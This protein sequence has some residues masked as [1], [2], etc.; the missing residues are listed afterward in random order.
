MSR[1]SSVLRTDHPDGPRLL[2]D[3]GATN[4]RF[5]LEFAPGRIEQIEVLACDDFRSVEAVVRAYLSRVQVAGDTQGIRHAAIAI[6][7]PI[8]GDLVRMTNRDWS[9][10]IETT[11]IAL[12]LDTLLVVN[13][14]TALAMAIPRLDDAQRLKIGGGAARENA[15]IGLLGPGTGLGVSG[16]IP[17]EDR[18]ITLGSEGGHV[19]FAPCDERELFVLQH[20]WRRYPHVSAERLVSGPGIELTYQALAAR[21]GQPAATLTTPQIVD[22]A[23]AGSDVLCVETVECFCAMLGTVAANVA[24]TLGAFGGIYIG[25]GI[26]PRLGELFARSP[27]RARFEAKGRFSDYMA[28]I[29]SYLITAPYPAFLG[30]SAILAEALRGAG[31]RSESS[32][33][34]DSVRAALERL[35]RAEQQVAELVLARPRAV[36]GDPVGEIARQA[37]VSQPTVIRF[38][39][40]LGFQGLSDFKLKL[41]SGLTGTV[42]IR[43]SQVRHGDTAPDISAKVLDNTASAILRLRDSLNTAAVAE[44]TELLRTAR[45]I[46]FYGMGNSSVVAMDGQHKFFRFRIPT[47]AYPDPTMQQLAAGLLGPGD[48][49]VVVS[50]RGRLPEL[51]AAADAALNAGAK[52]IA[53]TASQ[54]PLARRASVCIPVDHSED[55]AEFIAMISRILHLLVIDVLAVGVAV[56]RASPEQIQAWAR[57]LDEEGVRP[58]PE[59]DGGRHRISHLG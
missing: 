39:R 33:L 32:P 3:I 44:A 28:R 41:A 51:V 52:V 11:R 48:V 26:V 4:A 16:L 23:L 2:A 5:A 46:E 36:L 17:T 25:G 56:G 6:A 21:A 18:W 8:D 19:S 37:A 34:L 54:S 49:A 38:C 45:R 14:F 12:Q 10:S 47:A 20:T 29:P 43:H 42:P 1:T 53:I 55:G 22:A 57:A 59:G 27:F 7:N 31:G 35:S 30:V 9:F 50:S 40:S 24:M 58:L 13:D 15:V